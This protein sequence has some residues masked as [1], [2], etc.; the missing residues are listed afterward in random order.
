[1]NDLV[2]NHALAPDFCALSGGLVERL[3]RQG[4]NCILRCAVHF[5]HSARDIRV[6]LRDKLFFSHKCFLLLLLQ[7]IIYGVGKRPLAPRSKSSNIGSVE[8]SRFFNVQLQGV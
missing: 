1:M 7:G 8:E 3:Q 6:D 4:M 5:V 2:Q